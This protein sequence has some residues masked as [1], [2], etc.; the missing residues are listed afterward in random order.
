MP[1]SSPDVFNVVGDAVITNGGG[2]GG[3]VSDVTG[4][5]PITVSPT[6]GNVVVS[7]NTTGVVSHDIQPTLNGNLDANG[8]N[9]TD[10]NNADNGRIQWGVNDVTL[11]ANTVGTIWQAS[12]SSNTFSIFQPIRLGSATSIASTDKIKIKSANSTS[13]IKVD[14]EANTEVFNLEMDSGGSAELNMP[15]GKVAVENLTLGATGTTYTFPNAVGSN[16]EVLKLNGT[17]LEFGTVSGGAVDSVTGGDGITASPTTGAVVLGETTIGGVAGS[18]TN[19][20]ITVN[21]KGRVTVASSG[22]GGGVTAVTGSGVIASSGGTTPDI[23]HL[24]SGVSAGSYTQAT[25]SVDSTGHV[26]SATAGRE[27]HNLKGESNSTGFG[28]RNNWFVSNDYRQGTFID[29]GTGTYTFSNDIEL[30]RYP[31][32]NFQQEQTGSVEVAG[33]IIFGANVPTSGR[34]AFKISI[35]EATFSDGATTPTFTRVGQSANISVTVSSNQMQK[36]DRVTIPY[37]ASGDDYLMFAITNAS[38]TQ[39]LSTST[40]YVNMDVRFNLS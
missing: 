18:Y 32:I 1:I 26:T 27:L 12:T 35:Y 11:V 9:L 29:T 2:G 37:T 16:G 22:T 10:S 14:N 7:L 8:N 33:Y 28:G 34:P 23:S 20:N 38:A 39:A 4:T 13:A 40:C 17:D 36:F 5:T 21:D 3:A 24:T 15:T 19:A 31:L 25:I 30:I 6:T